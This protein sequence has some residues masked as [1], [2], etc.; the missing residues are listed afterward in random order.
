VSTSRRSFLRNDATS[1]LPPRPG[2]GAGLQWSEA[3]DGRHWGVVCDI[4]DVL[5]VSHAGADRRSGA[6]RGRRVRKHVLI[7]SAE[8]RRSRSQSRC[9]DPNRRRKALA[10][11]GREK[12]G[13]P[14]QACR[15]RVAERVMAGLRDRLRPPGSRGDLRGL[16][17]PN[18]ALWRIAPSD[19]WASRWLHSP[20]CPRPAR[21]RTWRVDPT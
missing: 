3:R 7:G 16:L 18:S 1:S 4:R 11:D 20:P 2:R 6:L 5:S 9:P 15:Q 10:V 13:E 12:G 19:R 8:R 21:S 17:A 14:G